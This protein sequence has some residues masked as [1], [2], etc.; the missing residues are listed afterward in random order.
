MAQR[1]KDLHW[2][3]GTWHSDGEG[4]IDDEVW[5]EGRGGLMLGMHRQVREDEAPLYEFLRLEESA[6][7]LTYYATQRDEPPIAFSLRNIGSARVEFQRSFPDFPSVVTYWREEEAL[8]AR[9][10]GLHRGRNRTMEWRWRL[11][12][13]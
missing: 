13:E 12:R 6:E 9:I 4:C 11:R 8:C 1:L 7:G 3:V 5:L 2:M 10:E